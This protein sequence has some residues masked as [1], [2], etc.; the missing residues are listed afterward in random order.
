ME[1]TQ[2][3]NIQQKVKSAIN[4]LPFYFCWTCRV[5]GVERMGKG[6]KHPLQ[7]PRRYLCKNVQVRGLYY[8]KQCM[9]QC[10]IAYSVSRHTAYGSRWRQ[11]NVDYLP[12]LNWHPYSNFVDEFI[13]KH[14]NTSWTSEKYADHVPPPSIQ[15]KLA[16]NPCSHNTM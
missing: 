9:A 7:H 5:T 14:W 8:P 1:L 4:T 12:W 16:P 15:Q 13:F 2:V 6:K 3:Y 11:K 10:H